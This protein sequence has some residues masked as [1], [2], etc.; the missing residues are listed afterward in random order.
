MSSGFPTRS[1]TNH[2]DLERRGIVQYLY[3]YSENK[4]ADQLQGNH[5]ADLH[6]YFRIYAKS[7]FSHDAA[8]IMINEPRC[9]KTGFLHMR[10]QRRR[11]A[12]R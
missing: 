2:S 3:L 4:G 11:S 12:S 1:S 9:E 7:R 10:K 6:L 8:L 5:A